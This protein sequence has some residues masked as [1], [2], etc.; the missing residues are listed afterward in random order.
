MEDGLERGKIFD[1]ENNEE[2]VLTVQA[3]SDNGS[4][5]EDCCGIDKKRKEKGGR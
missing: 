1:R 3:R 4:I 2:A 5:T